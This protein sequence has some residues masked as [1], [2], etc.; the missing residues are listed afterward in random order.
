MNKTPSFFKNC[1]GVIDG[2]H[3]RLSTRP[4]SYGEEY[5][6]KKG[7]CAMSALIIVDDNKHIHHPNVK[8]PKSIHYKC[9]WSDCRVACNPQDYFS[10]RE[11]IIGDSALTNSNIFVTSN[12]RASGQA[13]LSILGRVGLMYLDLL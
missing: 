2:T 6:T 3:F 8:F 5:F 10:P 7:Q 11:Y 1:V 13:V 12:E 4:D 9:I